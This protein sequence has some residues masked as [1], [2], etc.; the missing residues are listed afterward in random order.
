MLITGAPHHCAVTDIWAASC[1]LADGASMKLI[2]PPGFLP[3][4][5]LKDVAC[6]AVAAAGVFSY[7]AIMKP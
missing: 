7:L 1:C 3:A 4:L 6:A 2:I 5:L